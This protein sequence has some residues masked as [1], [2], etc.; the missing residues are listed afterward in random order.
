MQQV[1]LPILGPGARVYITQLLP[2][3]VGSTKIVDLDA[4]QRM[5]SGKDTTKQWILDDYRRRIEAYDLMRQGCR[6]R[7]VPL[8]VGG[9]DAHGALERTGFLD[10]CARV[11]EAKLPTVYTRNTDAALV[12]AAVHPSAPLFNQDL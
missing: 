3:S 11:D 12:D 6:L 4:V 8:L 1:I 10:G 5:C 7:A 9:P 2:I